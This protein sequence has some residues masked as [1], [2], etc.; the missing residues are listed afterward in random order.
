MDAVQ[1]LEVDEDRM[2]LMS[3]GR[4]GI[5]KIWKFNQLGMLKCQAAL[6]GH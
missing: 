4:E 5:I 2:H 1:S 3:G 6:Y